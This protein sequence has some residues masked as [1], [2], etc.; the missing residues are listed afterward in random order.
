MTGGRSLIELSTS[1]GG[2]LHMKVVQLIAHNYL[3]IVTFLSM[4]TL[5]NISLGM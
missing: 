2:R 5:L 3:F 1:R 4:G